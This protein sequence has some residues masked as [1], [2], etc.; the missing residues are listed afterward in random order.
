[1]K[2]FLL[3]GALIAVAVYAVGAI[4]DATQTRADVRHAHLQTEVVFHLEGKVYKPGLDT[5]AYTLWGT[6]A[7]TVSGELVGPGIEPIGDGSYRAVVRPSLGAHDK[8]RLLGCLNDL[9]LERVRSHVES[10]REL[11]VEA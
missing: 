10:V 2:R 6:C 4:G 11:P 7:A 1:V 8:E 9:T 5:G 3:A